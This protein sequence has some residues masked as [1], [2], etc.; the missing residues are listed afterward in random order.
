MKEE[1]QMRG[2]G[3]NENLGERKKVEV[4]WEREKFIKKWRRGEEEVRNLK[5]GSLS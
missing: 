5:R 3:A 2:K 1:R 4:Q